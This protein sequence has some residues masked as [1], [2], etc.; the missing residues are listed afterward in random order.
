MKKLLV[1]VCGL[2]LGGGVLADD[3]SESDR[4][5]CATNKI[6]LCFEDGDCFEI[7][8]QDVDMPQFIIVD[9]KKKLLSTTKASGE[10]R[11]TKVKNFE[12]ADGK[13][14]M[15]GVELGRAYSILIGE[16]TGFMTASVARDGFTVS[17]FGACTDAKL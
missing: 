7:L 5:L 9:I 12:R 8:P 17:A 10:N 3:V 16:S 1:T 11:T 15:Q 6:M 13:L 14:I 4:I 2:L